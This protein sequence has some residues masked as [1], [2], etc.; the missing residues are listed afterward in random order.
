MEKELPLIQG[1]LVSTAKFAL[2][3]KV[4]DASLIADES[5]LWKAFRCARDQHTSVQRLALPA[6][7]HSIVRRYHLPSRSDQQ[8]LGRAVEVNTSV[9]IYRAN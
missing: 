3:L 5:S 9:F 1:G 8:R 2:S 4:S 6:S 7:S